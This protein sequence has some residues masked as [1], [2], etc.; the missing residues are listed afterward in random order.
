LQVKIQ[1]NVNTAE[2]H[3]TRAGSRRGRSRRR[4]RGGHGRRSEQSW[5]R[6][7]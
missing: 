7:D 3:T 1:I 2:S 5:S 4:R 6:T